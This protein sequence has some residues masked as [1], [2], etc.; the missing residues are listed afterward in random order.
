MVQSDNKADKQAGQT[1]MTDVDHRRVHHGNGLRCSALPLMPA[2]K[3][4]SDGA[5]RTKTTLHGDWTPCR[6]A[7]TVAA[8]W[9]ARRKKQPGTSTAFPAKPL[10]PKCRITPTRGIGRKTLSLHTASSPS[11]MTIASPAHPC[12]ERVVSGVAAHTQPESPPGLGPCIITARLPA[13]PS[14]RPSAELETRGDRTFDARAPRDQHEVAP[15]ALCRSRNTTAGRASVSV[16]SHL[17]LAGTFPGL[18]AK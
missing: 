13:A 5:A 11:G 8:A 15:Q 10:S 12:G 3:Q 9:R 1:R 18:G 17:P 7:E 16:T 4:S 2:V 14:P 6:S